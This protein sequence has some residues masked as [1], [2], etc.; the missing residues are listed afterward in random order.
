[1]IFYIFVGVATLLLNAVIVWAIQTDSKRTYAVENRNRELS[2]ELNM[3]FK[4]TSQAIEEQRKMMVDALTRSTL[5]L[6]KVT[7]EQEILTARQRT[8]EKK[9]AEAERTVN[10]Y[11]HE[12]Q[13]IE[14]T[15]G[16]GKRAII[17]DTRGPI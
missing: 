1:M 8:L 4:S 2:V 6:E 5:N 11:H 15:I 14:Q 10:V 13:R 3:K 12:P 7:R 9:F 16:R 17:P